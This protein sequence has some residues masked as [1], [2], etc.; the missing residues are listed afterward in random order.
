MTWCTRTWWWVTLGFRVL[1]D[2]RVL[3]GYRVSIGSRSYFGSRSYLDI[4]PCV[5]CKSS[6]VQVGVTV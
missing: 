5:R 4:G 6:G 3:H 2:S 1:L